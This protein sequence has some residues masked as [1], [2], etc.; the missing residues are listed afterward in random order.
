VLVVIRSKPKLADTITY[1]VAS[2][3][4]EVAIQGSDGGLQ[5]LTNTRIQL[6]SQAFKVDN[7]VPMELIT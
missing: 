2:K 7:H 4:V 5:I 3:I 6:S 1:W